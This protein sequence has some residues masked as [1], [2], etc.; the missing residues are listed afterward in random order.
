MELPGGLVVKSM[1]TNAGDAGSILGAG[2]FI[3][4]PGN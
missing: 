3:M 2:R 4:P 1:S